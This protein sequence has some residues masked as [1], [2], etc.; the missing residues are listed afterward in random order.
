[1]IGTHNICRPNPIPSQQ[2][3]LPFDLLRTC[4]QIYIEAA[5]IVFT[6]TTLVLRPKPSGLNLKCHE[7]FFSRTLIHI[8]VP[9]G[10]EPGESC[11]SDLPLEEIDSLAEVEVCLW[12]E[13]DSDIRRWGYEVDDKLKEHFRGKE[14]SLRHEALKTRTATDMM[15]EGIWDEVDDDDNPWGG[16]TF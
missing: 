15:W 2:A 16:M 12:Y 4:R 14:V 1:M 3:I 6:Q 11:V 7:R 8:D 13:Y 9:Q 10:S 5:P